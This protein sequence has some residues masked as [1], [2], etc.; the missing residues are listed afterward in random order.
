MVKRI[1]AIVMSIMI[2]LSSSAFNF[3]QVDVKADDTT[4]SQGNVCNH[5]LTEEDIA[6][7]PEDFWKTHKRSD[8]QEGDS[9]FIGVQVP[10]GCVDDGWHIEKTD[11]T[12]FCILCG[13]LITEDDVV[14][15]KS[16]GHNYVITKE[17]TCEED[18]LKEC[19]RVNYKFKKEE[20]NGIYI[21]SLIPEE[22]DATTTE[23]V[24][25]IGHNYVEDE[26]AYVEPTCTEKGSKTFVCQN[27]T[28]HTYTEDV[29]A[30]GHDYEVS[31]VVDPTCTEGGYT[32]KTCTRC[33]EVITTDE[34]DPLGHDYESTIIQEASCYNPGTILY[35]C[36]RCGDSYT[37]EI[38]Q[39]EHTGLET[40]VEPTCTDSGK[41]E[42]TCEL[43][44]RYVIE[45]IPPLGHDLSQEVVNPTCEEDGYTIYKCSRCDFEYI[46]DY[47]VKLGHNWEA[48]PGLDETVEATCTEN[49]SIT[50]YDECT[51][52]QKTQVSS[53][54][55]LPALGHDY[56]VTNVVEP[57]CT[58]GGYTEETCTRCGDV[59]KVDELPALGHDYQITDTVEPTCE[60]SGYNVYT[61]SRCGEAF[62]EYLQPLGH[63]FDEEQVEREDANCVRGNTFKGECLRCGKIIETEDEERDYS[64]EF[65]DSDEYSL[66]R[67][68]DEV[69]EDTFIVKFNETGLNK[70]YNEFPEDFDILGAIEHTGHDY[71][72]VYTKA[73]CEMDGYWTLTCTREGCPDPDAETAKNEV[74]T[75]I[76]A[77]SAIG[78]KWSL[79]DDDSCKEPTCTEDGVRCWMCLNDHSHT[80]TE[81][82]P[83]TGHK[84]SF[85]SSFPAT[86]TE[87][88]YNLYVC[89]IC[90]DEYKEYVTAK[91]PHNYVVTNNFPA[92]CI[93]EGCDVYTCKECGDTYNQVT[94]PAKG[95]S[96]VVTAK[97]AATCTAEGYE[98]YT[99][100]E[101]GDTYTKITTPAKGHQ[102]VE[103]SYTAPTCEEQGV[104]IYNCVECDTTYSSYEPALGHNYGKIKIVSPTC[105]E[106]GYTLHTCTNPGCTDSFIT[107]KKDKVDH[108]L[109]MKDQKA[110]TCAED[111]YET[112]EC[113]NCD[114]TETKVLPATGNHVYSNAVTKEA[115]CTEDGIM[116]YTCKECGTEYTEVILAT[117]HNYSKSEVVESTCTSEGYTVVTCTNPGCTDSYTTDITDKVDHVLSVIEQKEATCTENGYIVR[118]CANCDYTE[119]EIIP[120]TNHIF[121]DEGVN[122]PATCDKEGYTTYTCAVCGEKQVIK[123][124]EKLGHIYKTEVT[125][126]A[127][128]GKAGVVTEKCEHCGK[129]I[130]SNTINAIKSVKLAQTKF[131]YTGK[132]IKPEV[133]VNDSKGERVSAKY[134]TVTY[135]NNKKIGSATAKV[136][137][138]GLYSGTKTLKFKIVPK[139]VGVSNTSSTCKTIKYTWGRV[140]NA[141]GYKIQYSTS[142]KFKKAKKVTIKNRKI[143][144]KYFNNLKSG[145]KYYFRVRAYKTVKGKNY[146]GKWSSS[147]RVCN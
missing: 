93:T 39:L 128:F 38:P 22:C 17:P 21:A 13:E 115:T 108:V 134:Y 140:K 2:C 20:V 91:I 70:Y 89:D 64:I 97:F 23:G 26:E 122:T 72:V 9:A 88:G 78:H 73:T 81:K 43:C 14:V 47:V 40:T 92:T 45:S 35:K 34:V 106:E 96:Y 142:K 107:D 51:R 62:M 101:C 59:R 138:K 19:D 58:K 136:T 139:G 114:Y 86:C 133:I 46:G 132:K 36:S 118:G 119:K 74:V 99:C 15:D 102:F 8:F 121:D 95:H 98:V 83:A 79:L 103:T 84:Y 129:A 10:A 29:D 109:S 125:E 116:T 6:N 66:E 33:G 117:G 61:C 130:V 49:G 4:G 65:A 5:I 85:V 76:N 105:T 147:S 63:T 7:I 111:G 145:K 100:K 110:P 127:T 52:C 141:K 55:E 32:E 146:Y 44:G 16:V 104:R 12:G 94:T 37:E 53:V 3:M 131:A 68:P 77:N 57:T 135:K 60:E 113:A 69:A 112:R 126:P 1:A 28:S 18:G 11:S 75:V 31:K 27:D 30:L 143:C 144:V 123:T 24:E 80:Y 67:M 50:H 87:G 124:S 82:I 41:R 90:G 42:G 54:E 56:Q 48:N 137:F 25:A 71:N 120:A